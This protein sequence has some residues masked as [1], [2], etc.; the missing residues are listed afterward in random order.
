[1]PNRCAI[2]VRKST[3]HGLDMEFN[4]LQNQEES[5]KAYIASQAFNGWQY[6]KTYTDA[7]ISGGTMERPALK[8]MLDDMAHG[9]IN[10]VVVY[11]VDRLSRSILDFHNMMRY[12]EKYGANFVSITQSF[13]TSTSMGKLT[14]NMLLSFAQFEREVSSERVR[15]KIRASK[16]K[17]LWMGG[18]PPLGYDV[19]NKK[20]IPNEIEA[21]NVRILFEKYLELQSVNA[22][23]EYAA[24]HNIYAK[25]WTTAKG[26]TKGGRPIAKMSMH[27]ILRDRTYIGQIV[28]KTDNTVAPGEHSAILP[29]DLFDRVQAALRNNANNKSETHGSPNLLT[30]KLFNHTGVRFTNQRTCGKG[31]TNTHYYATRGFYLP[32]PQVDEIAI[33]TITEFLDADLSALPAA[34]ID[35]I[36][37]TNI[38]TAS[39]AEKKAF[40]QSLV[41]KVIYSQDKLI[42]YLAPDGAKLQPFAMDNFI[43]QK[44]EPMEFTIS[45][46][47]IVIT[48]PIILR[49]YVNTVFDKSKNVVLT[50][51]DNNHLILKAFATAWR[52]REMYEAGNSIDEISKIK[53]TS[54]RN[55]FKYLDL[56]FMSPQMVNDIL[57]AK[58]ITSITE[59]FIIAQKHQ[60]L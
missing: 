13:D 38:Q 26:I 58:H 59:L 15:D 11:K 52:Y 12:F 24:A 42:F 35:T 36:K 53:K 28:N 5:C 22:L 9:L 20:L 39:Y 21:A 37:R 57:S 14:L 4:S 50:V 25:Q 41:D 10:T 46:G 40:V 55:I 32:A 8:Q 19:I 27:R 31:K 34:T 16:A 1:M 45:D 33:N 56:A 23:T 18:N 6:H 51:T 47:R 3:E 60:V 49:K 17:G 44:S 29:N 48:V 43:N 7:A 30:G 2:Y 54:V